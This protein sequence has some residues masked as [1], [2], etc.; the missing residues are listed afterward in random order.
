MDKLYYT[1]HC[2][3]AVHVCIT[4]YNFLSSL[5]PPELK[6]FGMLVNRLFKSTFGFINE[7]LSSSAVRESL[8]NITPGTEVNR[9][10]DGDI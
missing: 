9:N 7:I 2:R 3:A 1:Y 6:I 4:E 10:Y 8:T 5:S